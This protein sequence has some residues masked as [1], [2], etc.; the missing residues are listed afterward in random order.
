MGEKIELTGYIGTVAET[1]THLCPLEL[2][3]HILDTTKAERLY[4]LLRSFQKVHITIEE[5]PAD[6]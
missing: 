4:P 1:P 3:A 5:L 6:E 2:R